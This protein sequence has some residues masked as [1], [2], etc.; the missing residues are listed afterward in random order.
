MTIQL[1]GMSLVLVTLQDFKDPAP[2]KVEELERVEA[3]TPAAFDELTTHSAPA[4]LAENAVTEDWPSFLGASREGRSN[5]A[6]LLLEWDERPKLLWEM[7]RGQGYASPVVV[8]GKLVF[9]H[10][11]GGQV[12]VDCLEAESGKR[13]WRRTFECDYRGRYIS[14]SGPRATPEISDGYVYVHGVDGWLRCLELSTGR[15][16]WQRDTNTEFKVGDDFFGVVAS[17]IVVGDLLIQNVG[18][19]GGPSVVAFDKRTGKA[20]WGAGEEW[21]PSCASPVLADVH[22][23]QR[24]FVV[25]GGE[26]RPPTGGL[27]VIDPANGKVDFSYAFRSRTFESVNG[28]SPIVNDNRV[29]LSAS[30]GTGSCVLELDEKGGFEQ[31]WKNRHFGL[32][33]QNPVFEQGLVFAVDGKSD[34]A[35]AV[36]CIDPESGEE[37]LREDLDWEET[38]LYKGKERELSFSVGEG[39]LLALPDGKM[40]LL[41]DNGHLLS[42]SVSREGIEVIDRAW[43]FGA[44]ESWTPPVISRGLLFVCQNNRER[45][46]DLPARLLC[47]D[48]RGK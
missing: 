28:A 27:M 25:A 45:F 11:Q 20:V 41:G 3:P 38:A 22:G 12:H 39:S 21:G 47:F 43:L 37:L 36:L 40:L 18:A 13:Y 1:L 34:R 6:P 19:P 32:Q 30:Y 8:N 15:T 5:E 4:A 24:L 16:L 35:G 29:F 9:T 26:S 23:K 46:G 2:P 42:L 17:P 14:N 31:R 48:L 33:F 44:N 10:R 7:T